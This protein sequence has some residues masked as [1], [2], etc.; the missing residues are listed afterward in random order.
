[1][2]I[3]CP[4][5]SP[6][7]SAH[8]ATFHVG[9]MFFGVDVK[10]VQEVL[11]PQ[12]MTPVPQAP[13]TVEGLINLRGQIVVA[14]D[15]R[16]RLGLPPRTEGRSPMNVVVQ[17]SD[18][19]VSLLVDEIGEVLEMDPTSFEVPPGNIAERAREVLSGVYKLS[20]SLLLVLDSEKTVE[21][22]AGINGP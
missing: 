14:I 13:R 19:P 22:A 17:T 7:D 6:L 1:M 8:L 4:P 2:D 3:K 9:D 16:A 10:Q 21:I 20:K 15:M 5:S 12:P 18:G 11:R